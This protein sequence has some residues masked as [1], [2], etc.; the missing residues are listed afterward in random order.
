VFSAPR[1]NIVKK[2]GQSTA[3]ASSTTTN[4]PNVL[5]PRSTGANS[6][7]TDGTLLS[8]RTREQ[9]QNLEKVVTDLVVNY[10]KFRVNIETVLKLRAVNIASADEFQF[11]ATN[12]DGSPSNDYTV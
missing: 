4:N 10:M 2:A 12:V 5:S 6:T 1:L 8:P 3:N 9:N 11:S 7:A